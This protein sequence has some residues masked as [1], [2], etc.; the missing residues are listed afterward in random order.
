MGC[1]ICLHMLGVL[2][3]EVHVWGCA[4]LGLLFTYVRCAEVWGVLCW[5]C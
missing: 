2:T 4:M 5:D 1:A 3:V